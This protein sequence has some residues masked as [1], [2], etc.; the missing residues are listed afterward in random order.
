MISKVE[1]GACNGGGLVLHVEPDALGAE[2]STKALCE[3]Y[4]LILIQRT[5][6]TGDWEVVDAL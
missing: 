6:V 2:E 3:K 5:I 1:W 4:N